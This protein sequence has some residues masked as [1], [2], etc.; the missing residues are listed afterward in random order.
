MLWKVRSRAQAAGTERGLLLSS[1][2]PWADATLSVQARNK[3][4]TEKE[5]R[6]GG[7][8]QSTA[9]VGTEPRAAPTPKTSDSACPA[10]PCFPSLSGSKVLQGTSQVSNHRAAQDI[11]L[12]PTVYYS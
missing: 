10:F 5:N 9:G 4:T 12:K 2:E 11:P 8:V 3:P 6:Q 1:T 7:K